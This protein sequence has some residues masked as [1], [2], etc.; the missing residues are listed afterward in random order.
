[1]SKFD[2]PKKFGKII[3]VTKINTLNWQKRHDGGQKG[4]E[5]LKNV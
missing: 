4:L 3:F 5:G 2:S 1:M